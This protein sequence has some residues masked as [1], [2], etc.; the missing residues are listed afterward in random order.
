[1][2]V[3][4]SK[5]SNTDGQLDRSTQQES[6]AAS[7]SFCYNYSS[8]HHGRRRRRSH[9]F[10]RH[11]GQDPCLINQPSMHGTWN[12]CQQSG[13]LL[14]FSPVWKSCSS[15]RSQMFQNSQDSVISENSC[16]DLAHQ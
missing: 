5:N 2:S 7:S 10:L 16:K 11:N 9:S 13:K 4:F 3:F 14:T 1:M 12:T 8:D 6:R 15:K